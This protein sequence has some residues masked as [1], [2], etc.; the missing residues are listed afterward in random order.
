METILLTKNDLT[1]GV[2]L[3]DD[4]R[5]V[6]SFI[7]GWQCGD[8]ELALWFNDKEVCIYQ[9]KYDIWTLFEANKLYSDLIAAGIIVECCSVLL[10][11]EKIYC[12]SCDYAEYVEAFCIRRCYI[13]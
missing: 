7:A 10:S 8:C 12:P 9:P 6:L 4:V 3:P 5:K 2:E 13:Q 11:C 1:S